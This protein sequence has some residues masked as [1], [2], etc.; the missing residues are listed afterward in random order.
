[1]AAAAAALLLAG[2]GG[3]DARG[4]DDDAPAGQVTTDPTEPER[5]DESALLAALTVRPAGTLDGYARERFPHWSAQERM[6]DTR[7]AVLRRDGTDVRTD[8]ACRSESGR[9]T[10]PADG[11]VWTDPEDVD[12]DH[13]VPLA[14]AWRSGA[15][16]WDDDLRERF[17]N[18]MARP[19]LMILTDE[20][21]AAKGDDPPD[22][23]K[24]PLRGY[25]CT[26][27]QNWVT[28]KSHYGLSVTASEKKALRTMLDR[29]EL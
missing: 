23:W 28:V 11:E 19:Q 26:Y 4:G 17:A 20:V 29:C 10:S 3:G 5:R 18:D 15:R 27:A 9:W 14:E 25:W 22:R 8:E 6:C 16:T 7:E 13:V 21:N 1:M 12:V 2:C 24:P